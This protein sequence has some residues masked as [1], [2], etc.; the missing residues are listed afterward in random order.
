MLHNAAHTQINKYI[1]VIKEK[2]TPPPLI[3]IIVI[4][5]WRKN[6]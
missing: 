1:K 5:K 3:I 4:K 6:K 2:D